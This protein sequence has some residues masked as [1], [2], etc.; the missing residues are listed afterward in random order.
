MAERD[1]G[2]LIFFFLI[3]EFYTFGKI[4]GQGSFGMVIEATDKETDTKWAIKKVNKEKVRLTSSTALR[5]QCQGWGRGRQEVSTLTQLSLR[6]ALWQLPWGTAA[7][8]LAQEG[9]L[10]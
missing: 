4:L 8:S 2:A 5:A 6:G 7:I 1:K 3:Q 10:S 9:T